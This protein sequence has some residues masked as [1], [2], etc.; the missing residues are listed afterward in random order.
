[1]SYM[2][3]RCQ[4]KADKVNA[5]LRAGLIFNALQIY[6]SNWLKV[7]TGPTSMVVSW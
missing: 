2:D 1:M 7:V 5:L 3:N 6:F 4:N